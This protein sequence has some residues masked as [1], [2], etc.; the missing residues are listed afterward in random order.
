MKRYKQLQFYKTTFGGRRL[1][2]G[3]AVADIRSK[4]TQ[5]PTVA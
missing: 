1:L 3:D 4:A 5:S 2:K